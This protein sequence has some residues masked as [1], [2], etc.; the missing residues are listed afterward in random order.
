MGAVRSRADRALVV[1]R[2]AALVVLAVFFLLPF[3]VIVR[4]AFASSK[5]IAARWQG[6]PGKWNYANITELFTNSDVEMGTSLRSPSSP[7]S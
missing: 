2:Y 4:T 6:L 7:P 3:H 1:V 5:L